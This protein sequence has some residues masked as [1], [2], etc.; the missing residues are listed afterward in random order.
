MVLQSH[1]SI[2]RYGSNSICVDAARS[3]S[4]SCG[5]YIITSPSPICVPQSTYTVNNNSQ[6]ILQLNSMHIYLHGVISYY[7][8]LHIQT[9]ESY[10][11]KDDVAL[12]TSNGW[13]VSCPPADVV[14]TRSTPINSELPTLSSATV[15]NLENSI[16]ELGRYVSCKLTA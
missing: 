4:S 16:D 13:I 11:C 2:E 9:D 5:A 6:H 14:A 12:I 7:I 8:L 15:I 3:Q 1:N 10:S